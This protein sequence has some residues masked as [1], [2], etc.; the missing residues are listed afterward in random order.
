MAS[1]GVQSVTWHAAHGHTA[2]HTVYTHTASGVLLAGDAVSLVRPSISLD[3]TGGAAPADNRVWR[4]GVGS[5]VA[6]ALGLRELGGSAALQRWRAWQ[7]M[8]EALA[9]TLLHA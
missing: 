1:V 7:R 4:S 6:G 9:P 5:G 3:W 8:H 2:G